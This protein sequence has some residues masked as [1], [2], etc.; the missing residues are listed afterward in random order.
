[1]TSNISFFKCMIQDLKHRVW[2]IA[3]SCLGS[4]LAMPILYLLYQQSWNDTIQYRIED[5]GSAFDVSAFKMN[6]ITDCFQQYFIITGGI[7]AIA[8]AFIV[9]IF[10]FQYVFSKKMMDQY[11]SIPITR[12][13]LFFVHYING[14]LIWFVP[15]LL[16]AVATGILSIFFLRGAFLWAN[17]MWV[18]VQTVLNLVVAFL[19]V[20]HIALLA[21]MISGNVLNTLINGVIL[22]FAVIAITGMY[23]LFAG[24]Y[25]ATHYSA[26]QLVLEKTIWAS[27]IP[28][29]IYQLVMRVNKDYKLLVVIMNLVMILATWVAGFVAYLKRPSELAE[30]GMKIKPLQV[31]FKAICTVLAGMC[32]WGIFE[33]IGR[34]IGWKIFG[35][36]LVGGLCYGILDVV[37]HMDFKAFFKHK[38]QMGV[39][40]VLAILVA[41]S[42]DFDWFGYDRYIPKKEDIAEMG[43]VVNG[44]STLSNN[45]VHNGERE[46]KYRLDNMEFTDKERIYAF[47]EEAVY[48]KS[49]FDYDY[50]SDYDIGRNTWVNVRVTKENGRS[51]YRT[52]RID[53][54]DKEAIMPIL[55]SE[56][57]LETNVLIPEQV[58]KD[59]DAMD[60]ER[61]KE[62]HL[63]I[64]FFTEYK[65][66]YDKEVVRE[67]FEAY[68]EDLKTN[69]TAFFLQNANV[70]CSMDFY[71]YDSGSGRTYYMDLDVFET[72]PKTVAVLEKYD[73]V[74][75]DV[76][77]TAEEV[78]KVEIIV[79]NTESKTLKQRLG[80][81]E[82]TSSEETLKEGSSEYAEMIDAKGTIIAIDA[83]EQVTV[84]YEPEK[85]YVARISDKEMLEHLLPILCYQQ[86]S[87]WAVFDIVKVVSGEVRIYMNNGDVHYANLNMGTFPEAYLDLF[88]LKD[89]IY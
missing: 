71:G 8:G 78:E 44:Y 7:I 57:Y 43:I 20:Y 14:F 74:F 76:I 77:P 31:L 80:L 87:K 81:E 61:A 45:Y 16:S 47:L 41:M 22:S 21:V 1:M 79:Y 54:T 17:A 75:W 46:E 69:S 5:L 72:M 27:P 12:K 30:Q 83:V 85:Q 68:N 28:A 67:I 70:V 18:L 9:G 56:E 26:Y 58:F 82:W 32:G 62:R 63:R 52:Y 23:E 65:E 6:C 11:H 2:Q 73:Y 4:F 33:L 55:T 66:V 35:A 3:L 36:V 84:A 29:A 37:F 25:F 42:F 38:V 53:I 89:N 86:P 60:E 15:M 40:L 24:Q 88:Q 19:L 48:S 51:Y 64:D 10:G 13:K 39:M 34:G 49:S 59:L 50:S